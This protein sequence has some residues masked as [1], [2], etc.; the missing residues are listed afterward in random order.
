MA[1]GS[2]SPILRGHLCDKDPYRVYCRNV[3]KRKHL[4]AYRPPEMFRPAVGP[5]IGL[6]PL[7]GFTVYRPATHRPLANDCLRGFGRLREC[8]NISSL[9][10]GGHPARR[11]SSPLRGVCVDPL[12]R[13]SARTRNL[14]TNFFFFLG[15]QAIGK[16]S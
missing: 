16:V 2:V 3:Y 13:G 15:F 10:T 1:V 6:D 7:P 11:A 9:Y 5:A 14:G 8:S 12:A 4:E